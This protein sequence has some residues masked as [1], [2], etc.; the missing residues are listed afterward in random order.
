MQRLF[1]LVYLL[2]QNGQMTAGDL[3][4]HFSVSA[5]TIYR[6]VDMLGD[7]GVP[8][9]SDKGRGGGIGLE[10]D[11]ALD[12][13]GFGEQQQR[14]IKNLS[15]LKRTP[16]PEVRPA[17]E[18]LAA[19]FGRTEIQWLEVDF[20]ADST[21][22]TLFGVLRE[23]ILS[24]RVV[25]FSYYTSKGEKEGR[26]VEPLKLV[27]QGLR[28]YLYGYCRR[29]RDFVW[30]LFNRIKSAV[31]TGEV[32]VRE[33]PKQLTVPSPSPLTLSLKISHAAATRAYDDFPPHQITR[34]PD[35]NLL[36]NVTVPTK[37]LGKM[38]VF[39]Y[40]RDAVPLAPDW[41][42]KEFLDS[43]RGWGL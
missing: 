4:A 16:Q 5:R 34:A 42:C 30:F 22:N 1:E 6:D 2:L 15:A 20:G 27:N 19:L 21:Q 24:R 18:K 39:S 43:L 25:H 36:V 3:A 11:F 13:Q 37:E 10:G 23:A 35:G 9:Y 31:L 41:F 38:L 17:M 29:T 32:F 33:T 26:L 28:W 40:G 14:L 8:I 12:Q 7:A